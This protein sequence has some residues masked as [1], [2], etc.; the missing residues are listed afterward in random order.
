M[1]IKKSANSELNDSM[2]KSIQNTS[3]AAAEEYMLKEFVS[4]KASL[5]AR[6]YAMPQ[7]RLSRYMKK[8]I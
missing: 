7:I 6:A 8:P 1:H 3:E 2:R 4:S 5:A